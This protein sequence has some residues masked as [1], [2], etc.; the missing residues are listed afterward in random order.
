MVLVCMGY[1]PPLDRS[2]AFGFQER[3]NPVLANLFYVAAPPIYKEMF[4]FFCLDKNVTFLVH[5]TVIPRTTDESGKTEFNNVIR[6]PFLLHR[7]VAQPL[8]S[9]ETSALANQDS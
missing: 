6:K 7:T 8:I 1:Y 4:P 2:N 3:Q 9:G 5:S